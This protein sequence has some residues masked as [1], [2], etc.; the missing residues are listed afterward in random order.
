MP[1]Q[2][3][4]IPQHG[5]TLTAARKTKLDLPVFILY[6]DRVAVESER[7]QDKMM[8]RCHA[9]SDRTHEN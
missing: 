3:Y 6:F 9:K 2:R 5:N 4:G 1:L 7:V 8:Q